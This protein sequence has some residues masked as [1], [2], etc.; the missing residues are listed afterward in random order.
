MVI[1]GI[2]LMLKP[3]IVIVNQMDLASIPKAPNG[4]Q[5]F[6]VEWDRVERSSVN[7]KRH[8]KLFRWVLLYMRVCLSIG[9]SVTCFFLMTKMV[10]FLDKNH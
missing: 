5:K 6:T 9:P 3:R 7:G 2:T 4:P 8:G 10:N 1:D